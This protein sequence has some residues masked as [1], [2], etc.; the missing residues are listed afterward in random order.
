MADRTRITDDYLQRSI[1]AA[2]V[3]DIIEMTTLPTETHLPTGSQA[4]KDTPIFS[5]FMCYFPK[6]MA[7]VARLS[8][9]GNDKHNP[10]QPL[11]WS[12]DKSADH[13]DCIVRHQL[14]AGTIDQGTITADNPK[15][16]LHDVSVAWRAMAQLELA[17]ENQAA[18]TTVVRMPDQD[19]DPLDLQQFSAMVGRLCNVNPS[20]QFVCHEPRMAGSQVVW[21]SPEE[22]LNHD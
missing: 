3:K 12:R 6:A 22:T 9:F 14:E 10:G 17:L 13:G 5:G 19:Q 21:A 18:I 2:H 11:H 16:F 15:G 4:R 7:E 8:K 20:A 1:E